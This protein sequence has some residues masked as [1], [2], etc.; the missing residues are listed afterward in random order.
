MFEMTD[1]SAAV[2]I[3]RNGS[4]YTA[5][6]SSD[7]QPPWRS[8]K[9]LPK[10]ELARILVARGCHPVDIWDAL[11]AADRRWLKDKSKNE[12]PPPGHG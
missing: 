11:D 9:P 1:L 2:R 10:D 5:I 7:S 6:V 8:P 3:Q 4:A 12:D